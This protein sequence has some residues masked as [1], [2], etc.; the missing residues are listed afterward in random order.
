MARKSVRKG[1][2]AWRKRSG[3]G[4]AHSR[5][6]LGAA[7][8]RQDTLG[9]RAEYFGLCAGAA[10]SGRHIDT[11]I[12]LGLCSLE[13]R[14]TC[15]AGCKTPR[16]YINSVF[17]SQKTGFSVS[18]IA[19]DVWFACGV[20]LSNNELSVLYLY[21]RGALCAKNPWSAWAVHGLVEEAQTVVRVPQCFSS[22]TCSSRSVSAIASAL[23]RKVT[24]MMVCHISTFS[25]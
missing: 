5:G 7:Q 9:I 8:R 13:R 3:G 11:G 23:R 10:S 14:I 12:A 19:R 2:G 4:L 21:G 15:V 1:L 16:K 24:W 20:V 18:A 25:L 17:L 22:G 6:C